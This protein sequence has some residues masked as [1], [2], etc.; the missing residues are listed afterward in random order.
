MDT[1]IKVIETV[2]GT[3]T[4]V[5]GYA[6]FAVLSKEIEDGNVVK[7]SLENSTPMSSSFMNSSFGELVDKFGMDKV[8]ANIRLVHY[9]PSQAISIQKYL[10][11]LGSSY[12]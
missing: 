1:I 6:L 5:E 10:Q 3:S 8:K 7:L 2:T 11:M 4:N 9:K 12:R